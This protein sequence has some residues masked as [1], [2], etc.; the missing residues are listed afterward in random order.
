MFKFINWLHLE[1][2]GQSLNPFIN[3]MKEGESYPKFIKCTQLILAHY[4]QAALL[5][6]ISLKLR[7][8]NSHNIIDETLQSDTRQFEMY[9]LSQSNIYFNVNFLLYIFR[10]LR[11]I[12][13]VFTTYID[14]LKRTYLSKIEKTVASKLEILPFFAGDFQGLANSTY[15]CLSY[16]FPFREWIVFIYPVWSESYF[17]FDRTLELIYYKKYGIEHGHIMNS[18]EYYSKG[19]FNFVKWLRVNLRKVRSSN[20]NPKVNP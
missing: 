14:Y 3:F 15:D 17:D 2:T 5:H 18:T 8:K 4:A 11:E 16:E 9:L 13:N 12:T 10:N 1:V 6:G 19:Q 7:H 20:P